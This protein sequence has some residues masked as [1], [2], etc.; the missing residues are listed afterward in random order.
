MTAAQVFD[1]PTMSMT[2]SSRPTLSSIAPR[3]ILANALPQVLLVA[4][5][6]AY[7][8]LNGMTLAG[9]IALPPLGFCRP[10]GAGT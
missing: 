8:G 9:L 6:W 10:R 1:G 4:G 3:W 7:L 5:S 2:Q